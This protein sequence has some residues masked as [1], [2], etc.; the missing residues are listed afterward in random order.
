MKR[1]G[2]PATDAPAAGPVAPFAE[3]TTGGLILAVKVVSGSRRAGLAG[4]LGG[5]LK[6]RVAAPAE[7]GRAN[8]ALLSLIR[9]WLGV[10]DVEIVSG[11]GNPDKRVRVGGIDHLDARRLADIP[12]T[13]E[14]RR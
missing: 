9:E 4:V 7:K 10:S 2:D 1:A 14:R 6:V 12:D 3:R 5:R 11:A 13:R 8:R